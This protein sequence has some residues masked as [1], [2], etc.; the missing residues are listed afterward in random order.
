MSVLGGTNFKL[1]CSTNNDP[2]ASLEYTA[3]TDLTAGVMLQL[4]DIVGVIVGTVVSGAQAVLVYQAAKILVPCQLV[5]T[6]NLAAYAQGS[7]VYFDTA[8]AN[9][10]TVSADNRLCGVVTKSPV[11]GD[12]EVEIHLMG[13]LAITT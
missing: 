3:G 8:D 13:A 9:V 4:N 11:S 6:G 7:K 12:T 5:T 1:R 2:F 10:N